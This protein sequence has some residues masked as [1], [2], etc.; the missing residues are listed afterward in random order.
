MIKKLHHLKSGCLTHPRIE[1]VVW[2]AFARTGTVQGVVDETGH[3][4]KRVF[5]VRYHH[6]HELCCDGCQEVG[7]QDFAAK[8]GEV[9]FHAFDDLRCAC[10]RVLMTINAL[11]LA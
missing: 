7:G 1:R 10:E 11:S 9:L 2:I 8:H 4:V 5:L 3:T 6:Q